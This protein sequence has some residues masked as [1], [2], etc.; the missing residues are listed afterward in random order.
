[1]REN[2]LS[3]ALFTK[4]VPKEHNPA[5]GFVQQAARQLQAAQVVELGKRRLGARAVAY[6]A[7]LRN[8]L[9]E[10]QGARSFLAIPGYQSYAPQSGQIFGVLQQ[11]K[12]DF[13]KDLSESQAKELQGSGESV[14]SWLQLMQRCWCVYVLGTAR[15]IQSPRLT[16]YVVPCD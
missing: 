16:G 14:A 12:E 5:P 4:Q 6:A 13:E 9:R 11:M 8:F 3:L 15:R 1:M 10:A 2:T 7:V